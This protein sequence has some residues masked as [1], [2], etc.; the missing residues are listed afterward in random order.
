VPQAVDKIRGRSVGDEQEIRAREELKDQF[1]ILARLP[2][3]QNGDHESIDRT[4]ESAH[5]AVLNGRDVLYVLEE[6]APG[7]PP[8][9]TDV[10]VRL[11]AQLTASGRAILAAVPAT[12]YGH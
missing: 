12:S 11:P 8:L 10:G 9:V 7:K 2:W 4:N 5:L 3:S 6:R 1:A